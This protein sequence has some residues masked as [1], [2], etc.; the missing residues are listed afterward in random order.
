VSAGPLT[1]TVFAV[2][3]AI[4]LVITF[5]AGRRNTD[6]GSHYVAGGNLT[7]WQN[8]LAIV[9][10]LLSASVFL[11]TV[12]IIALKGVYGFF[13]AAG[14]FV[15]FLLLLLFAA[16]PLR[17]LGRFT[18]A[19]VL[20]ARFRSRSVRASMAVNSL[21]VTVFYMI[22][23]L[24][25]AGS[26]I[27]VLLGVDY[28]LAVVVV[29]VL[30]TVYIA[31]GG[32]VAT[33]W[34]QIVKAGMLL[35]CIAGMAIA[36]LAHFA[37]SPTALF[38]AAAAASPKDL[39]TYAAGAVPGLELMSVALAVGLGTAA[40]PHILIRFLTVPDAREARRSM[41]VALAF[42]GA[43]FVLIPIL[44]YG[45]VALVGQG[46]ITK[47]DKA[48]NLATLQLA[49]VLGGPLLFAIVAAV[50]FA[51]ILAVVSGLVIAGSGALAHD[52]Y[53]SILRRGRSSEREQ[54]R[55]GKIAAAG[56]SVVSILL[57]LAA[58]NTNVAV[59]GAL[60]VVVAASANVPV[61][62]LLLFWP[63][64][65]TTGVLTGIIAGLA[66]SVVLIVL[67]PLVMGDGAIY[68]LSYPTLVS[69][70]LGFLGCWL[71][72]VLSSPRADETPYA[73]LREALAPEDDGAVQ[74]A[75]EDTGRPALEG[76]GG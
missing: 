25:A 53:H 7:G 5:L 48:G 6:A 51:T 72:T 16:E 31:V 60:A 57:S 73:E 75:A 74:P 40:L 62:L 27:S 50:A 69:V 45:A 55:A 76:A 49:D 56:I 43:A 29:G 54:V 65:T 11:G 59:L 15:A 68:P 9:G 4:T 42:V 14:P 8:G 39:F 52:L 24:V 38:N 2:V 22:A 37:F 71:G 32:M 64:L 13:F 12:G 23:Q 3:I 35:V 17:R 61:L 28:A 36:V 30:M 46:T 58:H 63:R 47:A 41:N 66:S 33:T 1:V 70:P 67:G 18:V 20:A 44:G 10:D 34:I 21:L 19:D 26:L